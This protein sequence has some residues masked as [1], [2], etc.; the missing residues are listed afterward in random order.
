MNINIDGHHIDITPPLKDYVNKRFTRI[1]EHFENITT[2]HVVLSLDKLQH[3]AE[4]Q[5]HFK[6][7]EIHASAIDADMYAAIDAVM[8]KAQR[9]VVKHKEK[10]HSHDGHSIKDSGDVPSREDDDES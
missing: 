9:Q 5:L 10:L 7:K 1:K 4:I 8:D 2:A 6:G 3:K